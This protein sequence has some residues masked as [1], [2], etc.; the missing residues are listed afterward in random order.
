VRFSKQAPHR[1][2]KNF[3]I[4]GTAEVNQSKQPRKRTTI[5]FNGGS[6][7]AC[8][9]MR[10]KG[11]VICQKKRMLEVRKRGGTGKKGGGGRTF[12]SRKRV[13][14]RAAGTRGKKGLKF[15]RSGKSGCADFMLQADRRTKAE[16]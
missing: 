10:K 12:K 15:R 3:R 8:D 2:E 7:T 4:C 14:L 13:G 11:E 1:I 5:H 6:G 16:R 9:L